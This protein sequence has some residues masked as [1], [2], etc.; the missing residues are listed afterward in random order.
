[1][2]SPGGVHVWAALL[3]IG[4]VDGPLVD[5]SEITGSGADQTV[6]V[7][8]VDAPPSLHVGDAE[9]LRVHRLGG[10]PLR[11]ETL[12]W[13]SAHPEVLTVDNGHL[14]G[15]TAGTTWVSVRSDDGGTAMVE[16]A[17]VP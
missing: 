1:M 7:H 8:F 3:A 10:G 17:V 5:R 16:I 4:C 14:R 6:G 2:G 9:V 11:P 13:K 15:V 12:H